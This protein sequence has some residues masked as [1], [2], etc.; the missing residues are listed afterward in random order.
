MQN[1]TPDVEPIFNVVA[2]AY[3]LRIRQEAY[4]GNDYR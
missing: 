1:L 3:P 2:S 4:H